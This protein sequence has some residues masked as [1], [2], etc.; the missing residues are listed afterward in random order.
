MTG[1][2]TGYGFP[3]QPAAFLTLRNKGWI[4]QTC[5]DVGAYNGDWARE[6]RSIFPE[7]SVLMVEAQAGKEGRLKEIASWAPQ[8]FSYE[9]ALLGSV[10]G[11]E[12]EFVEMETGSSVFEEKSHYP[13][14]RQTKALQMLDTVLLR[15]ADYQQAQMLKID[16]QGYEL[17]VMRGATEL[18]RHVEVV[19]M[20]VSLLPINQGAPLF[21]EVIEFMDVRGFTLFDFCSQIRRRDG[22][23]WQTDLMFVRKAAVPGIEPELT[24]DNWG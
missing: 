2:K 14:T 4:P 5:I 17:E 15:H 23:L 20:E 22:V 6:F 9:I 18:M 1:L 21:A 13:R 8:C 24:R 19:L 3:S 16:T 10:D 12:V 11:R 7:A